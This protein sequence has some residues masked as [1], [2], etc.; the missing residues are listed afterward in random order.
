MARNP[1]VVLD[2]EF[3]EIDTAKVKAV[4]KQLG[5]KFRKETVDMGWRNIEKSIEEIHKKTKKAEE[6]EEAGLN[7]L[8][9]IREKLNNQQ[10]RARD[11]AE[12]RRAKE[13]KLDNVQN[14]LEKTRK[15]TK[16][17][18]QESEDEIIKL[19]KEGVKVDSKSFKSLNEKNEKYKQQLAEIDQQMQATAPDELATEINK[20]KEEENKLSKDLLDTTI[21]ESEIK[22]EEVKKQ[23]ELNKLKDEENDL[24]KKLHE[25]QVDRAT[26]AS[27][28][29]TQI[30][31]MNKDMTDEEALAQAK[32]YVSYD[33]KQTK[34]EKKHNELFMKTK[35][36][37]KEEL[38]DRVK[39]LKLQ[40]TAL[41]TQH[42]G[43]LERGLMMRKEKSALKEE[44]GFKKKHGMG[45]KLAEKAAP[46]AIVGEQI[47]G[48]MGVV[49]ELAAPLIAL[50]GLA[51]IVMM[52]LKFNKDVAEGRK[53]LFL[54]GATGADAWDKIERVAK[55]GTKETLAQAAATDTYSGTLM[56]MMDRVGMKYEEALKNVGALTNA[57]ITLHDVMKDNAKTFVEVEHMAL[58]SG[59]SFGDM[60]AISGEWVTDLN[61]GTEK[62]M[63]TFVQL[64]HD[65]SNAGMTTTRFFSSVMNA[66]QGL[67]LYGTRVTDVS[68][69]MSNMVK[70]SKLGQAEASKLATGLVSL[71]STMTN[72]QKMLVMQ[73]TNAMDSLKTEKKLLD[74][75]VARGEKLTD[76]EKARSKQLDS[77]FKSNVGEYEQFVRGFEALDPA[78]QIK[79]AI[80]ATLKQKDPNINVDMPDDVKKIIDQ[81]G[82]T[83]LTLLGKPF[84]L[85][86]DQWKLIEDM[87][88]RGI[89][90][91][92]LG[93]ELSD[94]ERKRVEQQAMKQADIIAK[95]TRPLQDMIEEGIAN[96]LRKLYWWFEKTLWP[97]IEQEL[98]PFIETVLDYLNKDHHQ[99]VKVD[100]KLQ[101]Q[102][103]MMEAQ[104]EGF[105]EDIAGLEKSGQKDEAA[106]RKLELEGLDA[107]IAKTKKDI[108]I[109]TGVKKQTGGLG[110]I[111]GAA[112][113]T[114]TGGKAATENK[115]VAAARSPFA[116][117]A[118]KMQEGASG[119]G[120]TNVAQTALM[121][122]VNELAG[123]PPKVMQAYINNDKSAMKGAAQE[124]ASGYAS[125]ADLKQVVGALNSIIDKSFAT[126]GYTG[127]GSTS[128]IAGLVHNK[129]FVFDAMSTK[130]M[131][132]QNL[133]T[134]MQ[135][136]KTTP[137]AV[138]PTNIANTVTPTAAATP[139]NYNNTVT[140]QVNQRDRQEIE[141][142]IRKVLYSEKPV[143]Y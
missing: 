104:R 119:A 14:N 118:K 10:N 129:E 57:G 44:L 130:K 105:T 45:E 100:D 60:A 53:Q 28:L 83:E 12:D 5:D 52:I 31:K 88:N 11:I 112:I 66:A 49:A 74:D 113:G 9:N 140:I 135:A 16:Q 127:Q 40:S 4:G 29:A 23:A 123:A 25:M 38:K 97:F 102:L 46:K 115:I 65:A 141:Q 72:Q 35:K 131:G 1:K 82:R 22:D 75:R 126:G 37:R 24:S 48:L 15:E 90:L 93:K 59:K 85:A 76:E 18:L 21:K 94:A 7:K 68:T 108:A 91:N 71:S 132:P 30:K 87:S 63:G 89:S 42:V 121:N 54:L 64:R 103:K 41:K 78:K 39:E 117:F 20:L 77:I 6:E 101:K 98:T 79:A 106:K 32:K 134:L 27:A 43:W 110:G 58:L 137:A 69:A 99:A 86:E 128:N 56:T 62:L 120:L 13:M 61:V 8:K 3:N 96:W 143:G 95:G 34:F 109:I 80:A 70:G 17:K 107:R 67:M 111:A 55:G 36:V 136:I 33:E 26:M 133:A 139:N 47:S 81:Y 122:A 84:G 125:G 116:D 124:F 2:L 73:T 92:D 19:K 138:N 114:V 50:A 142:I 51:G